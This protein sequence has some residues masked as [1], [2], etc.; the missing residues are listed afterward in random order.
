MPT[1]NVMG[2]GR[3]DKGAATTESATGADSEA[4]IAGVSGELDVMLIF[5]DKHGLQYALR[6]RA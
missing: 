2:N 1:P 6:C 5:H 3:A 4:S